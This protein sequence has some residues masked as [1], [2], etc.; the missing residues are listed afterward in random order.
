MTILGAT[1]KFQHPGKDIR[2]VSGQ[3]KRQWFAPGNGVLHL[4]QRGVRAENVDPNN[5]GNAARDA[6]RIHLYA[7]G[8]AAEH[9]NGQRLRAT[10]A[11]ESGREHEAPAGIT[12]AL[13]AGRGKSLVS[14]LENALRADINPQSRRHLPIHGRPKSVQATELLPISPIRHQHGVRNSAHGVPTG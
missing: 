11:A 2:R 9:G 1:P 5:L 13:L 10:H 7:E 4:E 3:S 8:D 6:R 12:E 14:A